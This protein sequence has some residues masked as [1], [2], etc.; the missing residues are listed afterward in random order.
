MVEQKFDVVI[1]GAGSGG[2]GAAYA[3]RKIVNDNP[4]KKYRIAIVDKNA[5]LGGTATEGWVTTWLQ[6]MIPPH[7][8]T[9]IHDL[10]GL[11][12]E[13]QKDYWLRGDFAK[14]PVGNISLS[15]DG[16][17]LSKR[18]KL[19]MSGFVEIFLNHELIEAG[20]SDGVV[21]FVRVQ[22]TDNRGCIKL[23][24]DYYID[25]TGDGALCRLISSMS[26][27][28][29]LCGRDP[30]KR[31]NETIAQKDGCLNR[32]NEAS[33]MYEIAQDVDDSNLLSQVSSVTA[34]YDENGKIIKITKPDY[35]SG[36]G[37]GTH[38]INPMTGQSNNPF[39]I[40]IG[41]DERTAYD[42]YS[43]YMLEHWKFIKMSCQQAFEKGETKYRAYSVVL[44]NYGYTG[45]HAPF[46][47][48]R[49]T[50]RII[51]DEMMTQNDM[52]QL[53]T[54]ETTLKQGFVGE[55]SHIVDFHLSA[56][57]TG[58]DDFNANKLRPHG[59]K[60]AA[61]IPRKM[62]NVL[63]AS[64]CYGA[65]QI[66]L[67]GAR[68]NFTIAYL[69]YSAGMAIGI[70]LLENLNDVRKVEIGKL[71]ELSEFRERVKILQTL[72]KERL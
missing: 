2:M 22:N 4:E 40:L 3:L 52:T 51:C 41:K 56:G 70:C 63:I 62:K 39:D 49:E 35:I 31:F 27:E 10:I 47:G 64:R 46:L 15:I 6:A 25:A 7:M 66:F 37:Y 33:L 12:A 26:D 53:I 58:I 13:K 72:Y 65:S 28:D 11:S 57:L 38:V 67:A 69:G 21:E 19:D 50:Y 23:T 5:A 8:E 54:E 61:L 71:Q 48:I 55:S 30:A 17:Q 42:I 68:G 45:N 16:K 36:D 24:A 32:I 9:I 20:S 60:Y 18:Y 59:I 29:Y 43:H 14:A 1:L 34:Q 44:R